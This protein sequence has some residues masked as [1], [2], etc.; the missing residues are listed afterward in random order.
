MSTSPPDLIIG[1]CEHPSKE[2]AA[3]PCIN[4]PLCLHVTPRGAIGWEILGLLWTFTGARQLGVEV[5][6]GLRE[7]LGFKGVLQFLNILNL[8]IFPKNFESPECRGLLGARGGVIIESSP[9]KTHK[10]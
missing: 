8:S 3:S 2:L 9:Q 5:G 4:R 6:S 7:C 1:V 10:I